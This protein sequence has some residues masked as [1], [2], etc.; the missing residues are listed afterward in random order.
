MAVNLNLLPEE[1]AGSKKLSSTVKILKNLSLIS[2]V[3]LIVFSLGVITFLIINTTQLRSL[4]E[5]AAD[6]QT[7]IRA[8]QTAEQKLVLL[9]DRLIKAKAV[10]NLESAG[11][12]FNEMIPVFNSLPFDS[13][14]TELSVDSQKIDVS[15]TFGS[16][17][18]LTQFFEGLSSF[19][20][21]SKVT[22]TSFGLN[23][24]TG[25]VVGMRF[26]RK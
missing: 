22:L 6:L 3:L 12:N 24:A 10:G 17:A 18:S 25:Y 16:S 15:M 26:I 2:V 8:Q 7:Q 23:P 4:E 11:D 13:N 21:F 19:D 9:K 14:L 1:L 20:S 5:Q